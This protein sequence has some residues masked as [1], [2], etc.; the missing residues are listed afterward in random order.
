MSLLSFFSIKKWTSAKR[1]VDSCIDQLLEMKTNHRIF[2]DFFAKVHG[3]CREL[4]ISNSVIHSDSVQTR[5]QSKQSQLITTNQ[6]NVLVHPAQSTSTESSADIVASE[7]KRRGRPPKQATNPSASSANLRDSPETLNKEHGDVPK[8]AEADPSFH[9]LYHKIIEIFIKNLSTKF[10]D[11]DVKP[12]M[13]I[14]SI[15]SDEKMPN[16]N[17]ANDLSIYS[18]LQSNLF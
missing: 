11:T 10:S 15:I 4:E 14:F 17:Q 2:K 8:E 7:R 13:T 18:D 3:T 12:I 16:V 1:L 5:G 6:P 9:V